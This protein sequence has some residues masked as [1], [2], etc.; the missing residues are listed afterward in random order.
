MESY[1]TGNMKTFQSCIRI[2][3]GKGQKVDKKYSS[4][5]KKVRYKYK[6]PHRSQKPP[7]MY[8]TSNSHIKIRND[9][10]ENRM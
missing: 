3:N 6:E 7:H 9:T 4:R 2:I 1:T 5:R 8:V 10:Y